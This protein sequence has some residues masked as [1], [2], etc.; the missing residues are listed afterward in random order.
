MNIN[1]ILQLEHC[2]AGS[3]TYR[4]IFKTKHG[5]IVFLALAR[6][7]DMLIIRDCFYIDRNRGRTGEDRYSARPKKLKT[8]H[9]PTADLLTV[10]G[11][12]LD[13]QFYGIEYTAPA[14]EAEST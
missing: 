8:V 1:K 13:K 6:E 4:T 3:N 14:E 7:D 12:E 9:L 2:H 10:I 11:N 5:R